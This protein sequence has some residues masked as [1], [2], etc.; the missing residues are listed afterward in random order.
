MRWLKQI[1]LVVVALLVVVVFS[2]NTVIE[3]AVQ[4]AVHK[5]TGF[6]VDI[7]KIN[8]AIVRPA[9]EI[10]D[11]KLLNPEDFPEATAFEIKQLRVAYS[12]P[13]LVT[14]NPRLPEVII[15]IPKAVVV[16]KQDGESNID[17]MQAATGKKETP[18]G[19]TAK[20]PTGQGGGKNPPVQEAAKP[21]M[22]V[23]IDRLEIRLG[24]VE[25]HD[26]SQGGD[27]PFV[28]T[29]VLNLNQT[30]TDITD[31]RQIG[32]IIAGQMIGNVANQLVQGLN[33]ALNGKDSDLN[34]TG[35]KVS[36]QLKGFFDQLE[37]AH[38]K[39]P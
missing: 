3:Q 15:D 34:K 18:A 23:R 6:D 24:T 22:K 32:G 33:R 35:E 26:Y 9:F 27:K 8:A 28:K 21:G 7:G 11:T 38:P 1:G 25:V 12:I 31:V 37:N 5:T 19:G 13:S 30:Y 10:D 17:R 2:R 29:Y 39:K 4:T 20:D 16:K 14:G 36:K